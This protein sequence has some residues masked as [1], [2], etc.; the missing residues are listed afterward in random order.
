MTAFTSYRRAAVPFARR[1][2]KPLVG[3]ALLAIIL[4]T[5]PVLGWATSGGKISPE[6]DRDAPRVDVV[7]ELP[8]VA[9]QFHRETLS[10]IG[11]YAGRDRTQPDGTRLALRAVSQS[12]L[13][14]LARFFWVEAI[15]PLPDQPGA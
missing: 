13:D 5:G 14:R 3:L 2:A 6:V 10:N 9:R 12:S 15:E 8:E 4:F 1:W 7:V 11:V